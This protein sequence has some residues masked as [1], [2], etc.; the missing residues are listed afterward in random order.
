MQSV[1]TGQSAEKNWL[2]MFNLKLDNLHHLSPATHPCQG[3]GNTMEEKVKRTQEL[4]AWEECCET[5]SSSYNMAIA[6]MN[7]SYLWL[8]AQ[9]QDSKNGWIME[10]FTKSYWQ[11]IETSRKTI[12]PY[13]YSSG[14]FPMYQ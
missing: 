11:L 4:E 1:I 12:F 7:P 10:E 3:F 9:N 14:M 6:D 5:L 8:P 2:G 13:K